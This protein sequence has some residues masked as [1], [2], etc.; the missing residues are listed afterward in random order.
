M[1][2]NSIVGAVN[3]VFS[4]RGLSIL[5]AATAAISLLAACSSSSSS[6]SSTGS[7]TSSAGSTG[8]GAASSCVATATANTQK[9]KQ[10]PKL[11]APASF[12][13]STMK[14]KTFA[15]IAQTSNAAAS[16][17]AQGM[18]DALESVGA[19]L[20]VLVAHGTSDQ[21]TQLFR[22]AIA[23][24][25]SGIVTLGIPPAAVPAAY[26]EAK[27]AKIP[28]VAANL[29][30]PN[31]PLPV[32]VIAQVSPSATLLGQIQVDYALAATNCKLHA[33]YGYT[34][35]APA[36]VL[37]FNAAQ[38]ELRKL[39]PTDC[40]LDAVSADVATFQTTM[41]GQVQ[42]T[43]Q[44]SS[45]INFVLTFSD[46]FAPYVIQGVKAAGRQIPVVGGLGSGLAA[47]IAGNGETADVIQTPLALEGYM[48]ADVIM[49]AASGGPVKSVLIPFKLVDATNW[50]ANADDATQFPG[51]V[52]AAATYKKAWGV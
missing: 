42:T 13:G 28:V 35:G 6:K 26:M 11:D 17:Q 48:N 12:N 37:A 9:A 22:T 20:Q 44:R 50:G 38:A 2:Q 24:K 34:A 43:L 51:L 52:G 19:S 1:E 18:K 10:E 14:G 36:T 45:D 46:T 29:G 23:Q 25:V 49:R 7:T 8:S 16:A 30:D 31:G 27:A 41:A 39:C 21:I 5:C 32:N 3:R 4:R 40:S 33:A 15:S 47:E